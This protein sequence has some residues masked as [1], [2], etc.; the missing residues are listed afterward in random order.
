[1]SEEENY[2]NP[3]S[4]RSERQRYGDVYLENVGE[5]QNSILNM[6]NKD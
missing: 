3:L 6:E 5:S 2:N 4:N 1:M